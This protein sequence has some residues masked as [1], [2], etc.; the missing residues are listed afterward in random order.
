MNR[1]VEPGGYWPW[2]A[3]AVFVVAVAMYRFIL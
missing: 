1:I 2:I 3:F